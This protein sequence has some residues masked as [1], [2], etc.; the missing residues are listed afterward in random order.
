MSADAAPS[1][2]VTAPTGKSGASRSVLQSAIARAASF[3]PAALATLGTSR[4][5]IEHYG[6]PALDSF[7]L[8]T[9]LILLIP[10]QDLGMGAAVTSAFAE[11]GPRDDHSVAV[12]LTAMR[13]LSVSSLALAI[14]S[15]I[16]AA[17]D[18]W[19]TLLGSAS[20]PNAYVGAA[21]CIYALTF[22]P[23]LGQR[24]LLGIERNHMVVV[25]Q[26]LWN[27][28]ML[29]GVAV[30]AI[31]GVGPAWIVLVPSTAGLAVT[32]LTFWY[33]VHVT[34]FPLRAVLTRIPFRA[35]YKGGSVWA[36]S[37]PMVV[38]TLC[39]P[40]ILQSDR[41]V[42]SHVSTKQVLANY[43]IT[44]QIFAPVSALIAAS[45]LP[46]WP[47]W[48]KARA[49]GE[50]GPS[51]VRVV[52]LFCGAAGVL[53]AL[54]V[55]IANPLAHVIGGARIHVGI[56]L[57]VAAALAITMQAAALPVGMALRDPPGLRFVAVCTAV[58]LPVNIGLAVG[59]A[60]VWGGPGPL[61]ATF[62]VTLF[63]QTLPAA[64][65]L[66]RRHRATSAGEAAVHD[67]HVAGE[68]VVGGVGEEQHGPGDVG[69]L[70][71][72]SGRGTAHD[73]A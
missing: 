64:A 50:R 41:I 15:A 47:M 21:V 72:P 42:L 39:V 45:A 14:A 69:R 9:S 18:A 24:M 65:Y 61:V 35:R 37:G 27:P 51:V 23:G 63:V 48:I 12:V 4:L 43:T 60:E 10:L 22:L 29:A 58:A 7:A 3:I 32:V 66:R 2:V 36:I 40:V 26:T 16:V 20:G 52:A 1:P 31:T 34:D 62:L 33:A 19:P 70:A 5:I 46:L 71:E 54:L 11:R 28:L 56:A 53:C 55:L 17:L 57:P 38:L 30:L 44:M 6:I 13:V 67:Q 49:R 25:I 73:L 59:L 68:V 8:V